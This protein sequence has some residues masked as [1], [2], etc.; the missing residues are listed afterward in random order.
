MPHL[1]LA[2]Y[3]HMDF[4]A[5]V[6]RH[7][8]VVKF[9][10]ALSPCLC[11]VSF[12]TLRSLTLNFFLSFCSLYLW[13]KK[14]RSWC[15]CVPSQLANQNGWQAKSCDLSCQN[16]WRRESK[17]RSNRICSYKSVPASSQILT[18]RL[19]STVTLF[20]ALSQIFYHHYNIET[21]LM[22]CL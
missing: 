5:S 7:L 9:F 4:E 18:C 19:R 22:V 3:I 17:L 21:T 13:K 11:A 20:C 15:G 16:S 1:L 2:L 6:P 14:K 8:L 10:I 12:I